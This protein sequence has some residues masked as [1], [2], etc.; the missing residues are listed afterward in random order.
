MTILYNFPFNS[1]VVPCRRPYCHSHLRPPS[2]C[3]HQVNEAM[4]V[5]TGQFWVRA[6]HHPHPHILLIHTWLKTKKKRTSFHNCN[7]QITGRLMACLNRWNEGMLCRGAA[8]VKRE[9]NKRCWERN[10]GNLLR[11]MTRLV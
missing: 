2:Q 5:I 1:V 9:I 8:R 3:S 6:Q 10:H 7:T 11:T 4:D